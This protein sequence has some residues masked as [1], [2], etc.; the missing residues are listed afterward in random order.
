MTIPAS[1]T[2]FIDGVLNRIGAPVNANTQQ[3]FVNWLAN[4]Q[5]G[6]N[7]T[8]FEANKGNPLGIQ[9]PEAQQAGHTGDV[10]TGIN[11]TAQLL[12][13]SYP[14]IVSAFKTGDPAKVAQAVVASPWNNGKSDGSGYGGLSQ[15]DAVASG[16]G[17]TVSNGT[18]VTNSSGTTITDTAGTANIPKTTFAPPEPGANPANFH[19]YDLTAIPPNELGNAEQAITKYISD[20]N[21]Q[22]QINQRMS[23]DFGYQIGWAQKIPQLNGILIWASLMQ[24]PSSAASKNLFET[25]VQRTKWWNQTNA[26]QRAWAQVQNTDPAQTAQALQDAREKVLADANQIG[27]KL[28]AQELQQIATVYAANTFVQSGALGSQSGT[29][30]EWL[31]Q[32][33]IDTITNTGQKATQGNLS[34]NQKD[35]SSLP[36]GQSQYDQSTQGG[37]NPNDLYGISSQL[38]NKFQTVAQQYLMYNPTNTKG[39]LLTNQDLMNQVEQALQNYTGSGSSFGSSNLING[40]VTQFTNQMK[41]Q[42]AKLYPSLAPAIAA[43]TTPQD[44]VAPYSNLIGNMMGIAPTSINFTDPKWNWV[45]ATPDPKTG[46]KTALT[47]DQVQ[48]KL[49]TLPQWQTSNTA[50]QMGTDVVASLNR[51]F[52]FGGS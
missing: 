34:T 46:Q 13:G 6:P 8:T 29:A 16:Q 1:A 31:D 33:I 14:S 21:L 42:A 5:G 32:A 43:G 19:G 27:V 37:T 26:N 51:Q 36:T 30:P 41:D 2:Q 25:A 39:S 23:Q 45:I 50:A 18:A 17:G 22:A 35:F 3:A 12:Q 40:A 7:L 11:L 20:P 4:E 38:Y 28:S 48:R 15:F 47:L 49:V 9:T 24:D 52:G 44:Y 10:Q